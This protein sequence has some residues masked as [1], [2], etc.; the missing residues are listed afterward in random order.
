M[1]G[2]EAHDTSLTG[3]YLSGKEEIEVPAMRRPVDRK[4]QLTIVGAREHNL[5][6]IDLDI[7][8][9]ELVVITGLS[10]S[11]K[12]SLVFDTIAAESQRLGRLVDEVMDVAR[13]G[14]DQAELRR[15]AVD[16]GDLLREAVWRAFLAGHD[17]ARLR[18]LRAQV[19]RGEKAAVAAVGEVMAHPTA[20]PT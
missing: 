20:Q 2:L 6:N 13:L 17:P 9:D 14:S 5:K 4:R 7:P 10:G 12:S 18:E 1:D 11:G 15:E 8:R 3:A 19:E 16:L